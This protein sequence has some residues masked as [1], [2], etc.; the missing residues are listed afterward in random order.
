MGQREGLKNDC[1]DQSITDHSLFL[2]KSPVENPCAAACA[3]TR[4]KTRIGWKP[5][6]F[7]F[8]ASLEKTSV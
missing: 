6:V 8:K 4:H 5:E 1:S 7:R 2:N 3:A